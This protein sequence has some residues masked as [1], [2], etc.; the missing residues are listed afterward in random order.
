[1]WQC[2]DLVRARVRV[3]V[4]VRVRVRDRIGLGL[5]L[6][7]GLVRVLGVGDAIREDASVPGEG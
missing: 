7:D 2:V 4:R 3:L 5:G 1:M 6:P